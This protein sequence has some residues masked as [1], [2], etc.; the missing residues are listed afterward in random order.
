[1]AAKRFEH[2]Q[3][4][5]LPTNMFG[6]RCTLRIYL[7]TVMLVLQFFTYTSFNLQRAW[8]VGG[9]VKHVN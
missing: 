9:E 8:H 1:M 5:I 7:R 3:R 4:F 6:I 2:V